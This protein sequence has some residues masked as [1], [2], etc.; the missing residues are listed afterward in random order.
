VDAAEAER[1]GLVAIVAPDEGFADAVAGYASRLAAGAP[2]AQA[3][4]KRLLVHAL[5]QPLDAHLR[6]ELVHIKYC[7]TTTDVAEAMT[8][9][10]EK[11]RPTFEGR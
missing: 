7:F 2:V 1:I 4:T 6:E 8:A 11:R 3:L 10:R 9:F 5:D